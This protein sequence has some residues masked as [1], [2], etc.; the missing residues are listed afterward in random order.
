PDPGEGESGTI[1]TTIVTG[2]LS[3]IHKHFSHFQNLKKCLSDENLV[4]LLE[5][6]QLEDKLHFEP[7]EVVDCEV[8]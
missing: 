8:K 5:E 7:I 4:I 2:K 6:F 3:G 1:Q